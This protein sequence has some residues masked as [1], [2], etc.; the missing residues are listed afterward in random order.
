MNRRWTIAGLL[1]ATL[2]LPFSAGCGSAC[3]DA[4]DAVCKKACECGECGLV[5]GG[6]NASVTL[7]FSDEQDCAAAARCE[8]STAT[9][10]QLA[11]CT[12]DVEAGECRDGALVL[13]DTCNE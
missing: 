6:E 3:E 13:P 12:A 1:G 8:D 7:Y 11:A 4:I 10:E 2:A 9:D 5:A